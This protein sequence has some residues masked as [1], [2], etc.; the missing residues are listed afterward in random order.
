METMAERWTDDRMDDLKHE[1]EKLDRRVDEG[2]REL[3]GEMGDLRKEMDRRFDRID[4]KFDARFD[5]IDARFD[6]LQR[7]LL[8]F[9][10]SMFGA[11]AS[12]VA[13]LIVTQL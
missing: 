1:V 12:L 11:M 6:G 7:S 8:L 4:A 9:G 13:A 10:A 5:S 3:R 2:F